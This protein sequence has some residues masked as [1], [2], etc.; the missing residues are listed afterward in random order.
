MLMVSNPIRVVLHCV[1]CRARH[2]CDEDHGGICQGGADGKLIHI[3]AHCLAQWTPMEW[4][5]VGAEIRSCLNCGVME[6]VAHQGGCPSLK[7]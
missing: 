2:L 7:K 6:G 1:H 3:C 5:C 4:P